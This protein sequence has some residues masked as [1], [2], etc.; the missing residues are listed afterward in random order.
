MLTFLGVQI[1]ASL[2]KR[3]KNYYLQWRVGKKIKLRSLGTTSL[4][5]AKEKLRQFESACYRGEDNLLPT[6]TP[7]PPKNYIAVVNKELT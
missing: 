6:K 7:V 5:I 1:M 4:Q 3:E 2:V